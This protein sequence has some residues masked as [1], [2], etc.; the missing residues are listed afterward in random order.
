MSSD[1]TVIKNLKIEYITQ[2]V[3]NYNNET[4][5]FKIID[6]H[7]DNKFAVVNKD[8][9]KLPYFKSNDERNYLLKVKSKYVKIEDLN[10]DMTYIVDLDLKYYKM[11]GVEGYYVSKLS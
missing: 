11:N 3:D 8:G 5:Y 10:K 9:Y 6:K 7:I 1:K 4:T 2:K